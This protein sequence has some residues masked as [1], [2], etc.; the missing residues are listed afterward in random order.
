[1]AGRPMPYAAN[2]NYPNQGHRGK[3]E[4]QCFA[5]GRLGES[6]SST[7]PSFNMLSACP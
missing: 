5:F 2:Y 1:M 7:F 6:A 3:T 4:L